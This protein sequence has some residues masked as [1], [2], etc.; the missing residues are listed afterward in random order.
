MGSISPSPAGK[1][2]AGSARTV[3]KKVASRNPEA[4]LGALNVRVPEVEAPT[5]YG[6]AMGGLACFLI[7]IGAAY[8]AMVAFLGWLMVWHLFQTFVSLR[9]GPYF[10]FHLPMALLGGMLMLFL[11]KPVFF[12]RKAEDSAIVTL[13]PADEPLLF[14]FVGKLCEA[15][16]ARRP[17]LIEVDCE[18]NA[19]ARLYA[20]GLAGPLGKDLVLRVGLPLVAAM[21]V[22][23]FAGVLAHEL[24]HFNQR[25]GMK[26]SYLIRM[27]VAFFAKIVFE[28]DRLDE[29]LARMRRARSRLGRF[30]FWAAAWLVEA[31]RGV[32][33][34]MMVTGELLT[35]GV[36][37]RM[38]Y[39][40]DRI[41]AHVAGMREFLIT[42]KLMMFLSIAGRRARHDLA[43]AWEQRRLAD[44]L[45][46][47]I[48]AHARQL[49]EHRD[50]ILKLL[51]GEKTS[52][53]DTHPCHND[54]VANVNATGAHG[55]VACDVAAKHLF[56]DFPVL[57][58]K[59][60]EAFYR[61]VLGKGLDEGKL[62]PTAE[63]VEQR[64]GEKE[65]FKALRRFF[66]HG[67]AATRPILPGPDASSPAVPDYADAL[68]QDLLS[69]RE[70]MLSL[71]EGA[72]AASE[73]YEAS[74]A[75]V[76]IN[77]SKVRLASIFSSSGANKLSNT[78]AREV[79]KH[80]PLRLRSLHELLAFESA[81]R[82]RLTAA[83]QLAQTPPWADATEVAAANADEFTVDAL[84]IVE[85]APAASSRAVSGRSVSQLIILVQ[86][87]EVFLQDIE[88]LRGI[89]LNIHLY[90]S[91]YDEAQPYPPLVNRIIGEG[92][93]AVQI[94]TRLRNELS[95]LTFPYA[96]ASAGVSVGDALVGKIPDPQDPA[97]VHATSLSAIDRF[98]DLTYLALAELTTHA[99]R[100]ERGIGLTP[101]SDLGPRE[102]KKADAEEKA[103]ARKNTRR[104]WFSYGL[105][106][107]GGIAMLFMLV[108][109]SLNPPTLPSMG[110]PSGNGSTRY[111]YRPASF[112]T[113]SRSYSTDYYSYAP[114]PAPNYR[115]GQPPNY[116]QPNFG[117]PG[118][119]GGYQPPTFPQ[120]P[121]NPYAPNVQPYQPP[122]PGYTPPAPYRPSPGGGGFS[123]GGGGGGRPSGGGGGGRR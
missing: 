30:I 66:R 72:G 61:T 85:G 58:K 80:D 33:W 34:L 13:R 36:L 8:F 50:D 15:T 14:E 117:Q 7:V 41:E 4:I 108:S 73:Q 39:D 21:T 26:G 16:G 116:S 122:Q 47:L 99:E 35:C 12:R 114:P 90:Y 31:A 17:V 103:E 25:G 71:A 67:A 63:L 44:D 22:R 23:Q 70:E 77:R 48:V 1:T 104:Y 75:A 89:S 55:L 98:Y 69:A 29:K 32:L 76:V 123:P 49:A 46:R 92:R 40:A 2:R 74:N 10:L 120:Q 20:K 84:A 97:E 111:A 83:L 53:F 88:K 51:D 28:R 115:P 79:G 11:I 81:A 24:G 93:E 109:W 78:S 6:W 62:V 107:A 102:N 27:M 9:Y 38:E 43:D 100:I 68:I 18:P 52:W 5:G 59:A 65:S 91:V 3:S 45:P 110:W 60:S 95:G 57:C 42:S 82:R 119:A 86:S 113:S 101:L 118:R 106:A 105:R 56:Q 112:S 94:L 54:R 64:A 19:G 96:H 37:R 121:A 87:L